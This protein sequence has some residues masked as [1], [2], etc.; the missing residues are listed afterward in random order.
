[1]LH[2]IQSLS[3]A[4][5][6]ATLPSFLLVLV[7][8]SDQL[9]NSSLRE[10][11]A[12]LTLWA[13]VRQ[14]RLDCKPR[15]P[16]LTQHLEIVK[17]LRKLPIFQLALKPVQNRGERGLTVQIFVWYPCP[18]VSPDIRS[19]RQVWNRPPLPGTF[20]RIS[21]TGRSP[22]LRPRGRCEVESFSRRN[23]DRDLAL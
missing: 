23:E 8:G 10:R 17:I 9:S 15:S 12:G 5:G 3:L 4:P 21:I 20:R 18:R 6:G 19:A 2:P 13:R 14:K 7:S 11:I 16:K 22:S 1:M